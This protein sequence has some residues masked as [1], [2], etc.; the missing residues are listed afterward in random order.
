MQ[1]FFEYVTHHPYVFSLAVLMAVAVAIYEFRARTL[2]FGS[3]SPADAVR[4]VNDGALL[5]DVR[6]KDAFAAGHISGARNVPG[7][8]IADGA[9][10]LERYKDKPVITYCDS[11]LTAGAATRH[12]GRLGFTKVFNLRGGL[13]AWQRD[14]LPVVKG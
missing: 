11:G 5:I 2:S 8:L 12:L 10:P 7:E 1:R 3:I 4:L 9:K 14:N 6:A 13:A